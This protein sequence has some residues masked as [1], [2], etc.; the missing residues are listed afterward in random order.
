MI[1]K[2]LHDKIYLNSNR[3]NKPKEASKFLLKILNKGLRHNISKKIKILDIGCANGELLYFLKKNLKRSKIKIDYRGYD[4]RNDLLKK[5]QKKMPDIK[6]EKIDINSNIKISEKFDIIICSGVIAIFDDL[7]VFFKNLKKLS[8]NKTII[9]FFGNFNE[10]NYNIFNKFLD[11]DSNKKVLQSGNNIWSIEYLKR[12]LKHKKLTKYKFNMHFDIKKN[13]KDLL[14][15]WTIKINKQRYVTN[16]L[17]ILYNQC[18]LEF[19]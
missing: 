15:T 16:C 13:K 14:R 10:Y 2:R 8:N 4:I 1:I 19:K 11:L 3:Y 5:A 6:F 18:W 9:Y 12:I 17:K 7:K